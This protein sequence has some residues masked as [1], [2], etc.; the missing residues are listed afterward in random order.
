[1]KALWHCPDCMRPIALRVATGTHVTTAGT[2][3][4]TRPDLVSLAVRVHQASHQR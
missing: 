4:I 3:T 1:M 2:H